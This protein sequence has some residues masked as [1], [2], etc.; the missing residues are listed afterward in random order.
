MLYSIGM[1]KPDCLHRGLVDQVMA[2]I[3]SQGFTVLSYKVVNLTQDQI[4]TLYDCCRHEDYYQDLL[5]FL[6]LGPCMVFVVKS[7]NA[8][9]RLNSLVGPSDP[10]DGTTGQIRHD[11]GESVLRNVIHSTKNEER[12]WAELDALFNKREV[13][14]MKIKTNAHQQR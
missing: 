7:P 9:S 8:I 13:K 12:F 5:S 6:R 1:L 4:N 3:V 11:F 10:Q 2:V 14:G